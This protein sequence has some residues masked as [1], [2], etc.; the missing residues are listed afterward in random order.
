[1][2]KIGDWNEEARRTVTIAV[3]GVTE[4]LRGQGAFEIEP[5]ELEVVFESWGK[6]APEE[7]F[8]IKVR[9]KRKDATKDQP[10]FGIRVWFPSQEGH[11]PEDVPSWVTE[12]IAV[13][14]RYDD[15]DDQLR[16]SVVAA[17]WLA[18]FES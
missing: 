16:A 13:F 18:G 5:E 2:P 3:E 10:A 14:T 8:K 12:L 17:K 9:G 7:V 4:P 6:S 11:K 1:M 15:L